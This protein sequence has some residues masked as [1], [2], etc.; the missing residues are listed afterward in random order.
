MPARA[1]GSDE[2]RVGDDDARARG[3]EE[4]GRAVDR[5][6]AA[7]LLLDALGDA[8][9]HPIGR[10]QQIDG[11][12]REHAPRRRSR[13]R[14]SASSRLRAAHGP[15][16]GG[17]RR[18]RRAW[19]ARAAAAVW[20]LVGSAWV[21]GSKSADF[22][23]RNKVRIG[24]GARAQAPLSAPEWRDYPTEIRTPG[25]TWRR[26]ASA[27]TSQ[28]SPLVRRKFALRCVGASPQPSLRSQAPR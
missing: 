18:L 19:A 24:I 23:P 27:V 6:L 16:C 1:S 22:S 2:G 26:P 7:G 17:R 10:D 28:P 3:E 4:R 21:S 11:N 12:K 14:R 15:S 25:A 8:V 5:E 13:R 9:A 20:G